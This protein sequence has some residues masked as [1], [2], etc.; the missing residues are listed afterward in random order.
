[1]SL[2][3]I[4]SRVRL[5]VATLGHRRL[6]RVGGHTEEREPPRR[7]DAEDELGDS[8]SYLLGRVRIEPINC[9]GWR[10]IIAEYLLE[11]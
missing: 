10:L 11:N 6:I 9:R 7:I 1:M 3:P 5:K 2:L 8:C 4:R